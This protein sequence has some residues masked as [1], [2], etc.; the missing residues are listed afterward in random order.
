MKTS[1]TELRGQIKLLRA[2]I[3]NLE[4]RCQEREDRLLKLLETLEP[5][6]EVLTDAQQKKIMESIE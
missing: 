6:V 4:V 3:N 2:Q 5:F 1:N